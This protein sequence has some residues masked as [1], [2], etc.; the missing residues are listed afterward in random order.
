M[1]ANRS[2]PKAVILA[3]EFSAHACALQQ[4]PERGFD[5]II[6]ATSAGLHAP[7][8]SLTEKILTATTL[9]Y[10]LSYAAAS[11]PFLTWA[12]AHG[13]TRHSDGLGMLVE[14]AAEAFY[15]WQG[16]RPQTEAVVL[17]LRRR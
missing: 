10:D 15:L 5:L 1:I 17:H 6:Q 12:Q 2:L 13:V 4:I 3:K 11:E 7:F 14:Q 9:C 16:V 8:F